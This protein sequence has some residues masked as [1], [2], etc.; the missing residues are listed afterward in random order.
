MPSN[1]TLL[2]DADLIC[3]RC[4]FAAEKASHSVRVGDSEIACN[5]KREASKLVKELGGEVH[6][7]TDVQPVGFALNNVSTV[8]DAIIDEFPGCNMEFY[9]TGNGN[10]RNDVATLQPYKG[11]R[12]DAPRPVHYDSIRQY[13]CTKYGAVVVDGQ[14]ADDA[15]GI[16]STALGDS[17]CIVSTDKDLDTIE[18]WHYN[19]V[20]KSLY[21]QNEVDALRAFYT[22]VLTGD[23]VD[24]VLGIEGCGIT[25]A[26]KIMGGLSREKGM[27]QAVLAAYVDAYPNGC[28]GL[29]ARDA[30]IENAKL[31]YIRKYEGAMWEVP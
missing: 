16:R 15:I 23:R 17:G 31:L 24:N 13:L 10:W 26:A 28:R 27:W 22:Q 11:N 12:V 14:E 8:V 18:G 1:K 9:L 7:I 4:G 19:W 6:T 20:K 5:S 30:A 21:F 2:V 25:T 29:T 3:Y